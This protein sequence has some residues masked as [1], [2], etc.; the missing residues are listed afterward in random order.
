MLSYL[1]RPSYMHHTCC[2]NSVLLFC[3]ET[4]SSWNQHIKRVV[5][6]IY[7]PVNRTRSTP[8]MCEY[9]LVNKRS[10]LIV[11]FFHVYKI[12]LATY[13]GSTTGVLG[14]HSISRKCN[15]GDSIQ[16]KRILPKEIKPEL[17]LIGI[18]LIFPLPIPCLIILF[19]DI[20]H[21]INSR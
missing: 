15:Q 7:L 21:G 9:L 5:H 19:S 10:Y 2:W 1:F 6:I 4:I 3:L 14:N 13:L 12:S 17:Y 8:I 20:F 18:T 11:L 16:S